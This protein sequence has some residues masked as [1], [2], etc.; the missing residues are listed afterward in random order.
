[1]EESRILMSACRTSGVVASGLL[2]GEYPE[3][4]SP[5]VGSE[6]TAATRADIE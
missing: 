5:K 2:D 4:E 1:V 3:W 6:S